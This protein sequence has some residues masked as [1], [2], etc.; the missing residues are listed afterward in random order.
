M[1]RNWRRCQPTMLKNCQIFVMFFF[2]LGFRVLPPLLSYI[3]EKPLSLFRPLKTHCLRK[4]DRNLLLIRLRAFLKLTKIRGWLQPF[5]RWVTRRWRRC[6]RTW[7][8]GSDRL[9]QTRWDFRHFLFS[10]FL[11]IFLL[12]FWQCGR[13]RSFQI[14]WNLVLVRA[15][16]VAK[17]VKSCK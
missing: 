12:F 14:K 9:P 2:F 15:Q 3:L 17:K 5:P 1:W 16:A 7:R 4:G 13:G 6:W 11:L 10:Y 8:H